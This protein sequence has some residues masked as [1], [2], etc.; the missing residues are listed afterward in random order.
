MKKRKELL[1]DHGRMYA[2]TQD[3]DGDL[4]IEVARIGWGDEGTPTFR[5]KRAA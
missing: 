2:L 1:I 3:A 4:Y 5:R